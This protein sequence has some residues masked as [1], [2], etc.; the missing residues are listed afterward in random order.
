MRKL[1]S[2]SGY[3]PAKKARSPVV[4]EPLRDPGRLLLGQRP[5][6]RRAGSADHLGQLA[7]GLD[8]AGQPVVLR[9]QSGQVGCSVARPR[10]CPALAVRCAVDRL[11]RG[12]RRVLGQLVVVRLQPGRFGRQLLGLGLEC[13]GRL[14]GLCFLFLRGREVRLQLRFLLAGLRPARRASLTVASVVAALIAS[15]TPR[16]TAAPSGLSPT[17]LALASR[18]PIA[19]ISDSLL[20]RAL[21]RV[22]G[23]FLR[24]VRDLGQLGLALGRLGKLGVRLFLLGLVG[25]RARESLSSAAF[26][27]SPVSLR[28]CS[29]A[30][31]ASVNVRFASANSFR[32]VVAA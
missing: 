5:G 27:M 30:L 31:V 8:V 16:T 6:N 28:A 32:A 7:D 18:S 14:G 20:S 12:V 19:L 1:D 13:R 21:H 10:P 26:L 11:R 9:L 2:A 29:T 3:R 17:N 24:R 23:R 22:V 25:G 15:S 4:E